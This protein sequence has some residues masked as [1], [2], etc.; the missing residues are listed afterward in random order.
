MLLLCD[1]VVSWRQ[2]I[3]YSSC[4]CLCLLLMYVCVDKMRKAE[5]EKQQLTK[6]PLKASEVFS[7]SSSEDESDSAETSGS[8]ESDDGIGAKYVNYCIASYLVYVL[9]TIQTPVV[10]FS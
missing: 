9:T 4:P 1:Y 6:E 8:S 5:T 7:E 2:A 10:H 3:S